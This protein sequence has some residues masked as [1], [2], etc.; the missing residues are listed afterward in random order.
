MINN[1]KQ[2]YFVV[3]CEDY[4]ELRKLET[5]YQIITLKASVVLI[6]QKEVSLCECMC[7][8]IE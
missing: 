7:A 3:F 8:H 5:S 6:S 2:K 4:S 1:R